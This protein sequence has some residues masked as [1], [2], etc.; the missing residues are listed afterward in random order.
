MGLTKGHLPMS[1]TKLT[2]L[3]KLYLSKIRLRAIPDNIVELKKLRKLDISSNK[4]TTLLPPSTSCFQQP[5]NTETTFDTP[6][7][8]NK[9]LQTMFGDFPLPYFCPWI[10]ELQELREL[11]LSSNKLE[12]LPLEIGLLGASLQKLHLGNFDFKDTVVV[13]TEVKV[14][15]TIRSPKCLLSSD[16]SSQNPRTPSCSSFEDHCEQ[17]QLYGYFDVSTVESI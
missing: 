17:F 16:P 14:Q 6:H 8:T 10:L 11:N 12:V 1:I 7:T 5:A 4:L 13:V 2:N 9:I 15:I 3:K